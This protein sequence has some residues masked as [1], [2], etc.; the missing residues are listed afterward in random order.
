MAENKDEETTT[1]T[2]NLT[3]GCGCAIV[4][5]AIAI[6]SSFTQVLKLIKAIFVG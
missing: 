5:I 1:Y 2:C 6:A 3:N 4:I